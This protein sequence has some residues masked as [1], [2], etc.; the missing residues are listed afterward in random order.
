MKQF[1][2]VAHLY[3]G[4]EVE[5]GFEGRKKIGKLVGKVEPFGWQVF[6]PSKVLVPYHNVKGKLF[7]PLLRPLSDMTEEEA[8]ELAKLSEYEPDFNDVKIERNKY[9]DII[10]SWQGNNESREVFNSTGELF[11]C[12]EQFV[13]LLSRSFDLFGLIESGQAIDKTKQS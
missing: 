10:V 8:V 13:Y 11:Y 5:F 12:A 7:K 4:C 9:N 3:I 1:S 6:Y 2:E